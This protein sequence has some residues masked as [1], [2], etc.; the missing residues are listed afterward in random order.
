MEEIETMTEMEELLFENECES[1]SILQSVAHK[2][3]GNILVCLSANECE[4][5]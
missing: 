4:K 3:L 5:L 1:C 2:S